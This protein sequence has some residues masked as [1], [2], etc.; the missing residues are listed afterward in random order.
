MHK[1]NFSIILYNDNNL[2][3]H[4]KR[5]LFIKLTSWIVGIVSN[6]KRLWPFVDQHNILSIF[7]NFTSAWLESADHYICNYEETIISDD[8]GAKTVF[9]SINYKWFSFVQKF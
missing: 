7:K 5:T 8:L 3:N 2:L 9:A 1:Q 4:H 6:I